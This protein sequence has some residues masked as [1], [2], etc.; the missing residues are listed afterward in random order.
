MKLSKKAQLALDKV[1]AKFRS[2]DLSPIV[3]VATIRLD[4]DAPSLKWSFGNRVIA[5]V[6]TGGELDCRGYKQWQAAGRQVK[7]GSR[8]AYIIGPVTVSKTKVNDAGEEEKYKQLVGFHTI[9]VFAY[10]QTEGE[11]DTALDYTPKDPPPL[12]EVAE[13]LG[14]QVS[15][16][17]LV[18]AYGQVTADGKEM[19]LATNDPETFFHELAHAAHARLEGKLR[20]G[21]DEEQETVAEFTAAVLM[22]MYGYGDRSGNA[23]EYISQYADDP[24][25]AVSKA[26]DVVG[27]V[28]GLLEALVP[29]EKSAEEQSPAL[30]TV[31]Q[32]GP[33]FRQ[34][35]PITSTA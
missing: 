23:W 29:N 8:A 31:C 22:E 14:V 12:I 20:G 17:P 3:K 19:R 26:L 35:T 34:G 7:K 18:G 1:I 28:V 2:G 11:D 25:T 27:K 21:Q 10:N 15:F 16:T 5:F 13:K 33:L 4:G 9:P 32:A 30:S 6:Q 24:L